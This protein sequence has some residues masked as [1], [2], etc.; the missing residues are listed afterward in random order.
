MYFPY[1]IYGQR[2]SDIINYV[3]V[4]VKKLSG[5]IVRPTTVY[6]FLYINLVLMDTNST[7][8][9]GNTSIGNQSN[10]PVPLYL[11]YL[12]ILI[13]LIIVPSVVVPAV[14][15]IRIILKNAVLK[16]RNNIF[17]VNLLIADVGISVF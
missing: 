9:R 17:F 14:M 11:T 2:H 16:T 6:I 5:V 3:S 8:F 13:L 4:M 7:L 10:G 12:Q 15:V 1:T